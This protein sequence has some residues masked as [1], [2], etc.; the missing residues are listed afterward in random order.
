[1]QHKQMYKISLA[2][3][4][5]KKSRSHFSFECNNDCWLVFNFFCIS[6]L[7]SFQQPCMHR[8]MSC[9]QDNRGIQLF[10]IQMTK[11]CRE[12]HKI[13]RIPFFSSVTERQN[14]GARGHEF[15]EAQVGFI[16][17]TQGSRSLEHIWHFRKPSLKGLWR[18]YSILT[19]IFGTLYSSI[20]CLHRSVLIEIKI[21][22]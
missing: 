3:C 4:L 6:P 8:Y 17:C 15:C 2:C 19:K 21:S 1:M 20:L 16:Q 12:Y 13:G 14:T 22:F 9:T 10:L 5:T 7:Q 11:I 18:N